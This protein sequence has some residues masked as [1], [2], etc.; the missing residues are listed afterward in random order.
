MDKVIIEL[1]YTDESTKKVLAELVKKKQK[2]ASSSRLFF[3]SLMSSFF[4]L[5][6]I[7]YF[8][9][10]T[11]KHLQ[12]SSIIEMFQMM[13]SDRWVYALIILLLFVASWSVVAKRQSD[14]LEDEFHQ[15]RIEIIENSSDF[16][17]DE[18][19]ENRHK[20]FAQLQEK[21]DINL[22]YISK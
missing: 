13:I 14:K 16:W 5:M 21:F 1:P 12:L 18:S 17:Q 4:L 2:Y 22:Y 9:Y 3:I 11:L 20:V 10:Q 7:W 15:L 8:G 19:W 6:G